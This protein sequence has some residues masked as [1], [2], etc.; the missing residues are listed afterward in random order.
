VADEWTIVA[1]HDS[2]ES[3]E[4][5]RD[6]NLT[7]VMRAGIDGGFPS[8]P[9]EITFTVHNQQTGKS[10]PREVAS[11]GSACRRRANGS[12]RLGRSPGAHTMR[13]ARRYSSFADR[14]R[15]LS[16]RAKSCDDSAIATDTTHSHINLRDEHL[17]SRKEWGAYIN[18]TTA[19]HRNM[20]ARTDEFLAQMSARIEQARRLH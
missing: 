19:L 9:Q 5:F 15:A 2:Q 7:P 3:F 12:S 16:V 14:P 17:A 13:P 6:G 10:T 11:L 20:V 8:P 18:L 4:R 1:V